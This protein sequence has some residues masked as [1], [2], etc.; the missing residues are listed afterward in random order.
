MLVGGAW[1]WFLVHKIGSTPHRPHAV[2]GGLPNP[3]TPWWGEGLQPHVHPCSMYEAPPLKR[4]MVGSQE[5]LYPDLGFLEAP[6]DYRVCSRLVF[7]LENAPW[8]FWKPLITVGRARGC[9][10]LENVTGHP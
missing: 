5:P 1:I 10:V 8:N 4:F 9:F 6:D 2:P 7:F 3:P